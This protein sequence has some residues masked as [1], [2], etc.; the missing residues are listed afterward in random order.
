MIQ[1][2]QQRNHHDADLIHFHLSYPLRRGPASQ[3]AEGL[4]PDQPLTTHLIKAMFTILLST[5]LLLA[6]G[7]NEI[8]CGRRK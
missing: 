2:T 5:F 8:C 3:C 4:K 1:A 6:F 7:A